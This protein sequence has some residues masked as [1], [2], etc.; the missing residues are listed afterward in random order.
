MRGACHITMSVA[1]Q[2]D[3]CERGMLDGLAKGNGPTLVVIHTGSRS[4]D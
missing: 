4:G 3:T 2:A 1:L